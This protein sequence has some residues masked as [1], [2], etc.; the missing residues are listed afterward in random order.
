MDP[1][2]IASVFSLV[3]IAEL[4]DKTQLATMALVA[5]GKP[6]LGVFL[7]AS[8]ALI[9]TT[10]LGVIFGEAITRVVS[11][12]WLKRVAGAGFIVMGVLLLAGKA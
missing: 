11:P 10:A 5:G 1:R 12:L 3:F 7:G 8:L 4:G 2:L 9:A 6:R